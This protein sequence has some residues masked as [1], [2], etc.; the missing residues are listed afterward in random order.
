MSTAAP[1]PPASRPAPAQPAR[2]DGT[3]RE[4]IWRALFLLLVLV[5]ILITVWHAVDQITKRRAEES[6]ANGQIQL[7][8]A[9][10]EN[11]T[12]LAE[13][14]A[15]VAAA[16]AA[17]DS[18]IATAGIASAHSLAGSGSERVQEIFQAITD[19]ISRAGSGST[20]TTP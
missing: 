18:A 11:R 20:S 6:F 14:R 13:A 10:L 5:L 16:D 1:R 19:T 9:R 4:P 17:R 2:T 7:R 12:R 15:R 8:V 3:G